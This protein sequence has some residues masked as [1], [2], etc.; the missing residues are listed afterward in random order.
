MRA[1]GHNRGVVLIMVV[2]VV[3]LLGAIVTGMLQ[4]NTED[5]QVMQNHVRAAEALAVAEAGLNDA[6]AQLRAQAGW[7]AGFED[8]AFAGGTYTVTVDGSQ[9]ISV[10][11]S[12]RG[13]VARVVANVT[14]AL[15]G[16]PHIVEIDSIKVNE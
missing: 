10:G 13:F 7:D 4:V 6:L 12:A 2:C 8:K 5:I 3:A 16:P 15:D 9:V 14:V 1:N 11:T